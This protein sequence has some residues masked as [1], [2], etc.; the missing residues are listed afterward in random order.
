MKAL[1]CFF[2]MILMPLTVLSTISDPAPE[3]VKHMRTVHAGFEGEVSYVAQFGDSITYSMAFWSPMGWSDPSK[4]LTGVDG[5]PH[6]PSGKRWRDV[7]KGVKDKGSKHG[8]YSGWTSGQ[9]RK[10]VEKILPKRKPEIAIIMVGSNDIRGG[11]V[12]EDYRENLEA[13]VEACLTEH[14]IPILNTLPPFR[15]KDSA[16]DDAN[17]IIRAIALEKQVPLADYHAACLEHRPANSWD[18]TLISKD[19]V[20]PSA[21]KTHDYSEENLMN[22]GYALR[23]WV[24]FLV[25]REVYF[26]VLAKHEN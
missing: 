23:N 15:G 8:N 17:R 21:G 2:C 4:Y 5:L 12:P 3:W 19:G 9:V 24:N 25:Y 11:G 1:I 20:H 18:G 6:T 10:A 7:I 26:R 16:V 13:I 14:C 22:S